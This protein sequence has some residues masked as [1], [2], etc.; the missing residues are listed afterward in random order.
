MLRVI[1]KW[2]C[3]VYLC[4]PILAS[5]CFSSVESAPDFTPTIVIEDF[6]VYQLLDKK[7]RAFKA[8]TTAGYESLISARHVKS[9]QQIS[10]ASDKVFGFTYA[11]A[12]AT[13]NTDW[14]PVVLEIRHPDTVNYLGKRSN[15]FKKLSS[16]RLKA[17]GRY[18]NGAFYI[19][20]EPYEMVP[21]EWVITITYG[22]SASVTKRFTIK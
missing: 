8:E 17:D 5:L 18:H 14:V 10:V 9:T 19:F 6:G 13:V 4:A 3:S 1:F 16:A 22:T 21:G 2:L 11:I 20:T 15:G 12:D 7:E